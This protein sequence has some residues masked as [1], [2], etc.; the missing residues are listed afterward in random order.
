MSAASPQDKVFVLKIMFGGQVDAFDY[1]YFGWN[2]MLL[3]DAL[4]GAGF[5]SRVRVPSF[6]LFDDTSCFQPF[7]FPISLNVVAKK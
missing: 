6:D 4:T 1:H 5:S 2:E 7:G 3:L